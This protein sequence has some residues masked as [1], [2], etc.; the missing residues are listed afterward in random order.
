MEIYILLIAKY[1]S[2]I[3]FYES[4]NPFSREIKEKLYIISLY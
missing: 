2:M 1:F 3:F 4:I